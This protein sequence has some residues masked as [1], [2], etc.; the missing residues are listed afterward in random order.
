[1]KKILLFALLILISGCSVSDPDLYTVKSITDGDTITVTNR[2]GNLKVRFACVDA[3]EKAQ[4]PWGDK[5]KQRLNRLI[6]E[7]SRVKLEIVNRDRYGRT[8]AEVYKGKTLINLKM[9]KEG[10]AFTYP[11]YLYQCDA[12]KYL[13]AEAKAKKGKKGVWSRRGPE[14]PWVFR[15]SYR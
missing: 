11:Q 5:A 6:P 2:E 4:K 14:K 13:D 10:Q 15:K 3:P 8:V 7:N 9:V 1:M 12:E